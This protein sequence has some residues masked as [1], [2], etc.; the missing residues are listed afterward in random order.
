MKLWNKFQ[1]NGLLRITAIL[2]ASILGS[3]IM[4]ALIVEI[5]SEFGLNYRY[6]YIL[7]VIFVAVLI[8]SII[9]TYEI[10]KKQSD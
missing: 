4:S 1:C 7:R 8:W 3:L 5:D 2:I 9:Y 6:R 10:L